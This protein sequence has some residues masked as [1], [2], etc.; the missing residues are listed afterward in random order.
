M[1]I[2]S[3]IW[4]RVSLTTC[5]AAVPPD[6]MFKRPWAMV[7]FSKN[8]FFSKTCKN[9][10]A[11][12]IHPKESSGAIQKKFALTILKTCETSLLLSKDDPLTLVLG[13]PQNDSPIARVQTKDRASAPDDPTAQALL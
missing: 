7:C 3:I 1:T 4:V 12:F 11:S 5:D 2:I 13:T 9:L 8:G 6:F 10:E